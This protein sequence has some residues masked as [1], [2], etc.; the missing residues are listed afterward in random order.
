MVFAADDIPKD[1]QRIVEFLNEQMDPAEVL[2]VEIRQ[3]IG[4]GNR[5][6]VPR[7]IGQTAE[8]QDRKGSGGPK[9]Q[10]D[11]EMF[12]EDIRARCSVPEVEAAVALL[13]WARRID[14]TVL[15]GHGR[16]VGTYSVKIPVDGDAHSTFV[17]Y[18]DGRIEL[19]FARFAQLEPFSS[20]DLRK[21]LQKRLNAIE[22]IQIAD[23]S[24]DRYPNT[25]L[26]VLSRGDN[27][28]QFLGVWDWYRAQL[29]SDD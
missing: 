7:V 13:G 23:E 20:I 27:V 14:A 26:Q 11:E 18:S 2:A 15:W 9:R 24:L 8:A 28:S 6:L 22:G 29:P 10:W 17:V 4:E 16:V 21:E 25:R 5:T 12:L 1:L 3:F 19:S